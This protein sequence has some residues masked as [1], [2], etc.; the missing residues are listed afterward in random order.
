MDW[1]Q[2]VRALFINVGNHFQGSAFL[3]GQPGRAFFWRAI[4]RMLPLP[5]LGSAEIAALGTRK[6]NLLPVNINHYNRCCVALFLMDRKL[7]GHMSFG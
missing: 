6:H 7:V 4:A 2:V 3:L 1:S 5:L